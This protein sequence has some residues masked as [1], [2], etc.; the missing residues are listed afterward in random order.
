MFRMVA[1]T[2]TFAVGMG[3]VSPTPAYAE[4][5]VLSCTARGTSHTARMTFDYYP[6]KCRLYWR[7]IEQAL[8]LDVCKPPVL[9]AQRPYAGKTDSF[10]A[11]NLKSGAF[12]SRFGGVDDRGRCEVAQF[13]D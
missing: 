4:K 9:Q 10:L 1:A 5:V 8:T 6:G 7:E 13:D 12:V 11:F 2:L 3:G